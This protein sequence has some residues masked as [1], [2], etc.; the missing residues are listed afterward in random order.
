M[1]LVMTMMMVMIMIMI[2]IIT[3]MVTWSSPTVRHT[4]FFLTTSANFNLN[5]QNDHIVDI[6][7]RFDS[8]TS[9]CIPLQ[10]ASV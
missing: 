5:D 7:W 8:M 4:A 2:V 3:T 9:S 1:L 6:I 10:T